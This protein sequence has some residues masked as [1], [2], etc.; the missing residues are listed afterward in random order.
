MDHRVLI[1]LFCSA[2]SLAVSQGVPSD[3]TSSSVAS[4]S[5]KPVSVRVVPLRPVPGCLDSSDASSVAVRLG[6]AATATG[7]FS[8]SPEAISTLRLRAD[9]SEGVCQI[10]VELQTEDTHLE[11]RRVLPPGDSLKSSKRL[12]QAVE[13]IAASWLKLKT[14]RL[15]IA[16]RPSGAQVRLNGQVVGSS[17]LS[18]PRLAP[19][20]VSIAVAFAGWDDVLDTV[21]L[22]AGTGAKRDYTLHRSQAWLDSV[23][24]AEVLRRHD[25][26]WAFARQSPGK[27]LPDLFS[28]LVPR[29]FPAGKQSVAILPF[30][31]EGPKPKGYD[32]GVMAA[33]YGVAQY[34]KDPRFVVVER[35]NLNRLLQEQALVQAG[36]ANDSGAAQAGKLL[37]VRYLVTGTVRIQGGK[38]EFSARLVSVETGEIVSAA[39]ASSASDNL[40]ELY[41]TA[42]GERGQLTASLYRS[43]V[44]PGWGQFYTGHPVHGGIALGATVASL[45]W[46]AWSWSD[47]SDKH[48]TLQKYR[49]GDAS[50]VTV[51]ESES[52]WLASAEKARKASNDAAT[53]VSLSLGVLGA[54]WVG[55]LVDA[56]ILGWEESRR[57]R[58]EYFSWAPSTVTALPNGALLSW[59]F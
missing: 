28:R 53:R 37:A 49:N 25:S 8:V 26:V 13:E 6:S 47:Y 39:V 23:R 32:P 58:T 15:E 2:S 10:T 5:V 29:D 7:A 40:E 18:L 22:E 45:A 44:G 21:L 14:S 3:P 27:A 24:R 12:D 1:L 57:I 55:N 51:G 52:E 59:R 16:T 33:E 19:G 17:P 36:A 38:Q 54:V 30:V 20:A 9:S 50:T 42:I 46:V 4:L 35:E 11:S 56:G 41:R 48:S 43:A 31:V 34:G